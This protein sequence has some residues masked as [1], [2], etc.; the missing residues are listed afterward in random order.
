MVAPQIEAMSKKFP[1]VA[2][3]KVDVDE[4]DAAA[5][6]AGIKAMPT[7]KLYKSGKEVAEL[8]GANADKLKALVVKHK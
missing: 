7:F 5:Q 2:F 4:N 1:D 8:V 3:H 6:D